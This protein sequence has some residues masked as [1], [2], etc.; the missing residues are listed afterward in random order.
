MAKNNERISLRASDGQ[1]LGAHAAWPEDEPVAGLVV[2]QEI[3]GVNA[4]IRRVT[5]AYAKDGF[6]AVAPAL[7]DRI[8]P[9][10]ELGYEGEDAQRTR[11]FIPRVDMESA[12]LDVEAAVH[13]SA[14][15]PARKLA[16]SATAGVDRWPGWQPLACR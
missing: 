16:S 10:V 7:F 9:N 2:V 1:E 5:D 6:L 3:F 8:E 15:P 4:H 11:S 14:N 13:Y 12:M